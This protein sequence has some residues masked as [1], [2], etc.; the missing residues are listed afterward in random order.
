M[1]FNVPNG[2]I[3]YMD[4]VA[5]QLTY[6]SPDHWVKEF[7]VIKQIHVWHLKQN[8]LFPE[9]VGPFLTIDESREDNNKNNG[10]IHCKSI[11]Y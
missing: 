3:H 1:K 2:A 7:L 8:R 4:H 6:H 10:H 9:L 11:E 5:G